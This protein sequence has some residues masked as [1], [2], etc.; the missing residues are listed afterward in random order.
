MSVLE[1][2]KAVKDTGSI[3]HRDAFL[4]TIYDGQEKDHRSCSAKLEYHSRCHRCVSKVA[5][6]STQIKIPNIA[7]RILA[8][9]SCRLFISGIFANT[10]PTP[11]KFEA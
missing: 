9:S 3:L 7:C 10:D 2:D 8:D 11:A 4:P 5:R 1:A 6:A